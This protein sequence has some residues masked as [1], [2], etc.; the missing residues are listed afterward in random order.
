LDRAIHILK[1]QNYDRQQAASFIQTSAGI[2][3]QAKALIAD[4]MAL[5]SDES[6]P[7]ANAYE[8][9]SGGVLDMLKKLH[10]DFR[11]QLSDTQKAEMNSK[12]AFNMEKQSLQD[13]IK[14]SEEGKA[15]AT[16]NKAAQDEASAKAS[17]SKAAAEASLA[18]DKQTLS[19][20][21]IECHQKKLSFDEKQ[22]LGSDEIAALGEAI[23]ILSGDSV[24][25]ASQRHGLSLLQ[26]NSRMKNRASG[27]NTSDVLAFLSAQG[28]KLHSDKLSLLAQKVANDPFKKVKKMIKAMV[29]K[30]MNEQNEEAQT[31]GFCD[32]ELK[33]NKLTRDR[34][35]IEIDEALA[36][37]DEEA[38]R[39]KQLGEEVTKLTAEVAAL[40]KLMKEATE[41]RQAEK[42]RNTATIA[43]AKAAQAA[44][45]QAT[46]VLKEF[47]AKAATATAFIQLP[48]HQ[49]S[50][51]KMGTADWAAVGQTG[52]GGYGQGSESSHDYGHQDGMQTFGET[53]SGQQ[54]SAGGVLAMLEVILSD[55]A[56]L[57]TKTA[58]DEDLSQNEFERLAQDSKKEKAVKSKQIE[59]K[60]A[61]KQVAQTNKEQAHRDW[62]AT[63]DQYLAADRYYE[64]LKPKCIDEGVSFEERDAKRAEEIASLKEALEMLQPQD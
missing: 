43:D 64:S 29:N 36:R 63:D 21:E 46:S 16:R 32:K 60:K 22:Q 61:D 39:E 38:A 5:N 31:K 47:Y 52:K 44:V 13:T 15:A 18:S 58:S 27:A 59:M 56:A 2:P 40:D 11:N 30:L 26:V 55:F 20:L 23:E 41:E 57:E 14:N 62:T 28:Q 34:L 9:Q 53:Y 8:F 17:K 25:G 50:R 37:K 49:E 33:T 19:D 10:G 51:V 12:H 6:G 35:S 54:D 24:E 42:E 1:N 45:A 3:T 7:E 4:F 48:A